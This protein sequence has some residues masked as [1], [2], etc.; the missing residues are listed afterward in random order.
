MR[1]VKLPSSPFIF[2]HL[3]LLFQRSTSFYA[4]KKEECSQIQHSNDAVHFKD[5]SLLNDEKFFRLRHAYSKRVIHCY[6]YAK[7]KIL[8]I[9]P[10]NITMPSLVNQNCLFYRLDALEKRK[11]R[12]AKCAKSSIPS[13]S[14]SF[15]SFFLKVNFCNIAEL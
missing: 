1:K 15:F 2:S 10:L 4:A 14:F 9:K 5:Y 3:S 6:H 12:T 13:P 11:I 7:Y 8:F